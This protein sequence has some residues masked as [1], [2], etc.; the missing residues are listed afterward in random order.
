[1]ERMYHGTQGTEGNIEFCGQ[2]ASGEMKMR[3]EGAVCTFL[4]RVGKYGS[5]RP[6]WEKEY[7]WQ[8]SRYSQTRYIENFKHSNFNFFFSTIFLSIEIT[9]IVINKTSSD[10]SYKLITL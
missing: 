9:I 4:K 2:E 5:Q 8:C 10:C 3:K 6:H 1:M 7:V